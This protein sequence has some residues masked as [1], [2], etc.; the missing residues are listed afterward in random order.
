MCNAKSVLFSNA[1]P[2]LPSREAEFGA[3]ASVKKR[4]IVF[5]KEQGKI[6]F[7]HKLQDVQCKTEWSSLVV[8]S[9]KMPSARVEGLSDLP[10]ESRTSA[11][12]QKSQDSRGPPQLP[13]TGVEDHIN[14][15]PEEPR[16]SPAAPQKSQGRP[17]LPPRGVED[18]GPSSTVMK[19]DKPWRKW[20]PLSS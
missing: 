16:T 18:L 1:R 4:H 19:K 6:E 10:Q 20:F 9:C 11:T 8:I 17:R 5:Q 12:L 7:S 3:W 13:S 14:Y 15:H 2:V